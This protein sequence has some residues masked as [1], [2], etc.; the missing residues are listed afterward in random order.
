M[1]STNL[2]PS[3]SS[4][5]PGTSSARLPRAPQMPRGRGFGRPPGGDQIRNLRGHFQ[6]GFAINWV[7]LTD[8]IDMVEGIPGEVDK[9][10]DERSQSLAADILAY[11]REN[12]PWE[13]V[14]GDAR[15]GLDV[16]VR[17]DGDGIHFI[18]F[19]TME[20]G[21]YLENDNGGAFATVIPTLEHFAEE[22]SGRLWGPGT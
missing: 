4:N 5:I 21:V 14:T 10:M 8:V 19:H 1:P 11:A 7:G 17:K 20:Y 22:M 2:I 12:A 6:T 18:L 16:E 3:S 13:D 15:E 9:E